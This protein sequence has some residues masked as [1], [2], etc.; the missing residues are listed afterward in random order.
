MFESRNNQG[1]FTIIVGDSYYSFQLSF[2]YDVCEYE[3]IKFIE[4]ELA[5]VLKLREDKDIYLNFNGYNAALINYF[6]EY[7]LERDSL[8]FEFYISAD[9]I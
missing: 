4:K 7:G 9:Y 5:E 6:M 1:V 2:Q 3:V 8:G